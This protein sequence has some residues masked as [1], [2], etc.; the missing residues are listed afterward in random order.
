LER[1]KEAKSYRHKVIKYWNVIS[2]VYCK[3]HANGEASRTAAESSKEMAK[4][5]DSNKDPAGSSTT[6]G[7]LKRERS[8]DSFTSILSKKLD[9]F[10]A[11]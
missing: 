2:L 8:G 11:V 10:A 3:D 4:E 6:S 9:M 5:L 7:S 1:N